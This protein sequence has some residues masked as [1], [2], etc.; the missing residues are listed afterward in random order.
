MNKSQYDAMRKQVIQ[1]EHR[2]KDAIDDHSHGEARWLKDKLRAVEDGLQVCKSPRS[3]EGTIK[4]LENKF[5]QLNNSP[6]MS[7]NDVNSF[8]DVM[9]ELRDNIR[10]FDNY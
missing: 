10:K 7:Q 2:L 1:L 5:N 4:Q 8:S 3:I 6:V 9:R